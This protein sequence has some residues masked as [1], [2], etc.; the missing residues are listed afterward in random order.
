MTAGASTTR[1]IV[2]STITA[3][4]SPI[5]IILTMTS[6]I[7]AKLRKTVDMIAAAAVMTRPVPPRPVRTARC[8]SP[9]VTY[10]SSMADIR[11]TS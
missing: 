8:G 10:S 9:V 5:P 7:E 11:K 6:S 1:M 3:A 4:A 2:A